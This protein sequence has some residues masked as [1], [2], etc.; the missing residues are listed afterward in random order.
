[1]MDNRI[2]VRFFRVSRTHDA[3]PHFADALEA[4]MQSGNTPKA[5]ERDIGPNVI[6]RIERFSRDG[7]FIDGEIVRRQMI[8]FPPEANDA[9]LVRPPLS[10][11][12]GI[13]H[14]VAFRYNIG[15]RVIGIQFDNRAVSVGRL[16][17][18][19]KAGDATADYSAAPL[20]RKDAWDRYNR[21][22]PRRFRLKVAN[23]Q[24][25]HAVEGEVYDVKESSSRLSEMFGG[26]VITLEVSMGQTR[27]GSLTREKV[28]KLIEYLTGD[29]GKDADVQELRIGVKP[30]D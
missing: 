4:A 2:T 26:P 24:L 1:M 6:V 30:L 12:G 10:E 7:T 27:K 9:G 18:Y 22:E 14:C 13:G 25:L 8:N 17:A 23:P 19:L 16:L 11:G 29:A 5:R 21:G 20:V 3:A 28:T 15:L